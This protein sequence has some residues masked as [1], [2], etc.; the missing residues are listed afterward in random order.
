MPPDD[1]DEDASLLPDSAL[2]LMNIHRAAGLDD[3][4]RKRVWKTTREAI[5]GQCLELQGEISAGA[6]SVVFDAR[7]K[8]GG[9]L[10]GRRLVVK[11]I[12]EPENKHAL[13]CF[14][15]EVKILASEHVPTDVVPSL[16]YYQDIDDP[17]APTIQ[18]FFVAERIDGDR[19]LKY[20][21]GPRPLPIAGRI[22]LIERAFLAL[23]RL[24]SC[25]ILHGDVSPNNVMVQKED[26]VRLVDLGLAKPIR[27]V[28]TRSY[29]VIGG[30]EGSQPITVLQG[31][32]RLE[33]WADIHALASVAFYVLTDRP[34]GTK[35]E[36]ADAIADALRD[37]GVPRE[38][39]LV[40][41]KALREKDQRKETDRNLYASAADVAHDLRAWRER[42][43]RRAVRKRQGVAALVAASPIL[44]LA[45]FG[46]TNYWS[47]L[48]ADQGREIVALR[49]QAAR[50]S[51]DNHPRVKELSARCDRLTRDREEALARGQVNRADAIGPELLDTLRQV[52]SLRLGL[53]RCLPLRQALA[54]VLTNTPWFEES[55]TIAAGR[56]ELGRRDIKISEL[57]E[58]GETEDAW[59]GLARLHSELADLARRN[60]GAARVAEP[61][62]RFQRA[63]A[64][65][66]AELRR[67]GAADPAFARLV[68]DA[69]A[70]ERAW[71][72]GDLNIAERLIGLA[73]ESLDNW[74]VGKETPREHE[75]RLAAEGASATAERVRI[76]LAEVG[77]L[78]GIQ[79]TL[80]EQARG[81]NE[82]IARL[83]DQG[84]RDGD[85]LA[86]GS[87]ALAGERDRRVAAET[88]A[89]DL[90]TTLDE[91]RLAA[92]QTADDLAKSRRAAKQ[93][94]DDLAKDRSAKAVAEAERDQLRGRVAALEK[95]LAAGATPKAG[96]A[97]QFTN[98]LDMTMMRIEPGEFLMG[99]TR[100]QIDLM[101]NQFPDLKPEWYDNEQPQHPVRITRPFYLGTHQVTVRQFR[102]FVDLSGYKTE[103]EQDDQ[104]SHVWDGTGW[105][106]D[107]NKTWR[108]PGFVQGDDH[109]VVCVSYNDAVAFIKWL[110]EQEKEKGRRY[111][112]PTEAEW[113]YACRAGT[114]GLYGHND[115]PES[116]VHI[117]N[118]ADAS[119]NKLSPNAPSIRGDD[120]NMHTAPAGS[121]EPNPWHL[122]DMIGDVWEWCDDWYD[123]K[124]YQT[125]PRDH[126]NNTAKAAQRVFRGGSWSDCPSSC[127]PAKRSGEVPEFRI[128]LL[129]FRVAADQ[130]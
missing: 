4:A 8:V 84:R 56:I 9:R 45:W 128:D 116:L 28:G 42:Q 103:A 75:Q 50:L 110:N 43:A 16:K 108:N 82:T 83:T 95:D 61:I 70:A 93:A 51:H 30:T 59:V 106:L 120:G 87:R 29:S 57:I 97:P 68:Q 74:L 49:S 76:L 11:V 40:L 73:K 113:E 115:D 6:T 102:R 127:R 47:E 77:R 18:P 130:E 121:Y 35:P 100:A 54:E 60:L 107:P 23:E 94:D 37:A 7:E 46:W 15:R 62:G 88:R 79:K 66:S 58:R 34:S 92:K 38:V 22:E 96:P 55:E 26:V 20:V 91:V 112:L 98:S 72:A 10:V 109:P 86:V 1:D 25:N 90:S 14:H 67:R 53:E 27:D 31:L 44:I 65:L 89:N 64:S 129:G 123:P 24:H 125:S 122:R 13:A 19:I 118:V 33:V 12:V 81:L 63:R 114:R 104:G 3:R 124:F 52:I 39:S 80:A 99:S 41:L 48:R 126:P 119:L 101:V 17:A 21:S 105:K 78:E 36:D 117:A 85:A 5:E 69:D 2:G 111:R 71:K 32:N